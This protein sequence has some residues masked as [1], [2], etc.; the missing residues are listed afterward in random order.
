MEYDATLKYITIFIPIIETS[1]DK[2]CD[3]E[4][5]QCDL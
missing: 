5:R 4:T 2:E 3:D 1:F